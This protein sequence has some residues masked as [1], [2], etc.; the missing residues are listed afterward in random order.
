MRHALAYQ[1]I[2]PAATLWCCRPSRQPIL[3]LDLLQTQQLIIS[4]G[5]PSS[6]S[7]SEVQTE[8]DRV[9]TGTASRPIKT[10]RQHGFDE[11]GLEKAVL[12]LNRPTFVHEGRESKLWI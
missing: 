5:S 10:D 4:W 6:E 1:A 7:Q 2:R 3:I 9:R 12:G 11:V 8:G